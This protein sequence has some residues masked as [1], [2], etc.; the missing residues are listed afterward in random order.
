MAGPAP[1]PEVV[2]PRPVILEAA[3]RR[4]VDADDAA[5]VREILPCL[6]LHR[7]STRRLTTVKVVRGVDAEAAAHGRDAAAD[8]ADDVVQP[9]VRPLLTLAVRPDEA[10]RTLVFIRVPVIMDT[11]DPPTPA[12]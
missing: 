9:A 10:G 11:S 3:L 8:H 5:G 12:A 7:A 1:R 4:D 2:I 6:P